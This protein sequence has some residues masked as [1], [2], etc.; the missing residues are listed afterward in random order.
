[1]AKR[2]SRMLSVFLVVLLAGCA[3]SVDTLVLDLGPDKTSATFTLKVKQPLTWSITCSEPWVRVHPASGQGEGASVITVTVDRAGL[4]AGRHGASL[5]IVTDPEF[6]S[7][8]VLVRMTVTRPPAPDEGISLY[9]PADGDVWH[10]GSRQTIEWISAKDLVDEQVNIKVSID[11]DSTALTIVERETDNTGNFKITA[12]GKDTLA[13][14]ALWSSPLLAGE[15]IVSVSHGGSVWSSSSSIA[16]PITLR[17]LYHKMLASEKL[18]SDLD[19]LPDSIERFLGTDPF[20]PD[21]D[22]DG[23]HDYNEIF[24]FGSF[25]GLSIPDSNGDGIIDA[26][27]ADFN[28]KNLSDWL[29]SDSDGDGIPNYLEYYG[30]TYDW[31]SGEYELW[32]GKSIDQTYFKTDPL[33]PSTDQDP[34]SDGMETSGVL[35]DV[36]VGHP[37]N[38]P[39][40]PAYPN[41]V[42]RLE[43]YDVTLNQDITIA[44]GESLARDSSWSRSTTSETSR[45]SETFWEAG[46]SVTQGFEYGITELGVKGKTEITVHAKGGGRKASTNTSASTKSTGGSITAQA[47]WQKATCTNPTDAARI[48][49][50]LKVYNHG[51]SAAST[52]IPTFTLKIGGM[53]VAT[54]EQGNAQINILE[55]GGVYPQQT[56]TYWVIDSID[57]GAGVVPISLTLD[58]LRALECGAPVSIVMTQM[59]A[60]VMLMNNEGK[61]ERAGDWGEYIARCDAVCSN[62]YL[63]IGDGSFIHYLVYSADS[64]TSPRVTFR[65]ALLWVADGSGTEDDNTVTYRDRLG[66]KKTLSLQDWDFVFDVDTLTGNGFTLS[67][68][69]QLIPPSA[70]YNLANLVLGPDTVIVGKPPRYHYSGERRPVV[71]YAYLD[72]QMDT[73]RVCASDY[74][75]IGRVTF[76]S[77]STSSPREME[78]IVFNSGIYTLEIDSSYVSSGSETVTVYSI[79]PGALPAVVSVEKVVYPEREPVPPVIDAVYFN[80]Y[81]HL[82]I[83]HV[84]GDP[85]YPVTGVTVYHHLLEPD[86]KREMLPSP[87]WWN[88]MNGYQA[89]LDYIDQY[90]YYGLTIIAV[91]EGYGDKVYAIHEVTE[92]DIVKD[93]CAGDMGIIVDYRSNSDDDYSCGFNCF[94]DC[95][96]GDFLDV[97]LRPEKTQWRI[98]QLDLDSDNYGFY[99]ERTWVLPDKS[100]N[101]YWWS[102]NHAWDP[103]HPYD[104]WLLQEGGLSLYF[105]SRYTVYDGVKS[106]QE[107]DRAEVERFVMDSSFTEPYIPVTLTVEDLP[108]VFI[109]R[110]NQGRYAKVRI[111]SIDTLIN[112]HYKN[113]CN[114]FGYNCSHCRWIQNQVNLR[115]VTFAN[116]ICNDGIDNDMDQLI[117]CDDH[118]ECTDDPAC[119]QEICNDGI[120]NDAD[121][122]IDCYDDDCASALACQNHEYNCTDGIDNDGDQLTDCAD[123]DCKTHPTCPETDCSDGVDNDW[124]GYTDCWDPDCCGFPGCSNEVV[125]CGDGIDNDGDGFIDCD[126]QDC[127][128]DFRCPEIICNDS[129]DNDGDGLIDCLDPD[130]SGS[131]VC[132]KES[133]CNDRIDNDDDGF[134]D[135]A[136][137]DCVAADHCCYPECDC[138]DRIDN[139]GDGF[140]DCD[141]TDCAG[142]PVCMGET[143]CDDGI[144]NDG[145]SFTDC[146]DVDCI[147][148]PLCC[149]P[150]CACNDN[151][152]NDGDGYIDCYDQDC[153]DPIDICYPEVDCDD[154]LDNDGDGYIDCDDHDCDRDQACTS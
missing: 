40:V 143:V 16:I 107:I 54:F 105:N 68:V 129:F 61:W 117:D 9:N 31:M 90:N 80:L 42:I 134:T 72:E 146:A 24:G 66:V 125:C 10:V 69:N 49:L 151:V 98:A 111:D 7:P 60:D 126:D 114:I 150:E 11:N 152:D 59:L 44:E 100:F 71:H 53:N 128:R 5:S 130:C 82:L 122:F 25:D 56:G 57:T 67:G 138:A 106:F 139:D 95:P 119:K 113:D 64:P 103:Q 46:I 81:N 38:L 2:F 133:L 18:D 26:L 136:D 116:E 58:E 109:T 86:G 127:Y 142:N 104:L 70:D 33:Q 88:D 144:D 30:Y 21:T 35:M 149:Y 52:I 13:D 141:D 29:R 140:V 112:Q 15:V 23:I 135:C 37:G 74:S 145:D 65:D 99:R 108:L 62:M 79:D 43:G 147:G 115:Y 32:S 75:G 4:A 131:P 120:D 27:D 19:G 36:S 14:H 87:R 55:P 77:G 8:P 17:L 121:G 12:F 39:M 96:Y 118:P 76:Q 47:S 73:V 89:Y 28:N 154:G 92:D 1:M 83:A 84:T 20:S 132:I 101:W 148:S 45:T 48:K 102:W 51:T 85:G 50:F 22:G 93:G 63:D 3:V 97:W 110:T 153:M 137:V 94:F 41:I 124:D 34:Y 6:P 123:P 78:E 91:A